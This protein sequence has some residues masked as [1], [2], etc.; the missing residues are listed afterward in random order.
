[1]FEQTLLERGRGLRDDCL[2]GA[3]LSYRLTVARIRAHQGCAMSDR[4][5]SCLKKGRSPPRSEPGGPMQKC[6][7]RLESSDA[8]ICFRSTRILIAV[9]R[10]SL[11]ASLLPGLSSLLPI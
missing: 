6:H 4:A 8:S 10:V 11:I 2:W 1:S 7:A 9:A 3:P 5:A